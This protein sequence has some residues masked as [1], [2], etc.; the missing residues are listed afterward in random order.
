MP[1]VMER[2]ASAGAEDAG[3]TPERFAEFMRAE[4]AKYSKL[5]KDANI[6]IDS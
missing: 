3:G 1:D 6:K 4:R 5:A 2:L